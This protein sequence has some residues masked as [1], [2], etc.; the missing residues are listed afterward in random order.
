MEEN[1]L[2]HKQC[3]NTGFLQDK[4]E[5]GPLASHLIWKANLNAKAKPVKILEENTGVNVYSKN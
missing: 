4:D 1:S 5:F 3:W 2:F